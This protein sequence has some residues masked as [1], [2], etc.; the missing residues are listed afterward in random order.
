VG[1]PY[2][3]RSVYGALACG[4]EGFP[5]DALWVI[6]PALFALGVTADGFALFE[7]GPFCL[8]QARI[9]LCELSAILDLDPQACRPG[10]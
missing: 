3:V 7:H 4:Q 1:R 2:L 9:D 10:C 5:L 8:L 6:D